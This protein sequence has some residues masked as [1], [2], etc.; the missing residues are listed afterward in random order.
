MDDD[1]PEVRDLEAAAEWRMRKV[2]A[3]PGDSASAAAATRLLALA[4]DLRVGADSATFEEFRAIR[5]WLDEFDGMEDFLHLAH[6]YRGGIGFAHAPDSGEAY[7]R[8]LID[9]AKRIFGAP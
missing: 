8:A 6:E 5:G 9:L 3:D 7:L 1:P 2:D 4:E